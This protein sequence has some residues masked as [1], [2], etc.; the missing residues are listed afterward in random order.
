MSVS[1]YHRVLGSFDRTVPYETVGQTLLARLEGMQD[2]H[3]R[4]WGMWRDAR[5]MIGRID[6]ETDQWRA[7]EYPE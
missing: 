1:A 3:V 6:F 7:C 4:E 2:T 5:A